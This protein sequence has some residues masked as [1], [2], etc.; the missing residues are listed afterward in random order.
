MAFLTFIFAADN[1][2]LELRNLNLAIYT[3]S[4]LLDT[5]KPQK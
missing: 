3:P 4:S 2:S 1:Q 5:E